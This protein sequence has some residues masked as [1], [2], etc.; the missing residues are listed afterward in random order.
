MKKLICCLLS[1][2]LIASFPYKALAAEATNAT[3][4][5]TKF[6]FEEITV[7]QL[8]TT[9]DSN[10]DD[11]FICSL[12]E[13]ATVIGKISLEQLQ[14]CPTSTFITEEVPEITASVYAVQS[15]DFSGTQ[16]NNIAI[17]SA[18]NPYVVGGNEDSITLNIRS[19][20]WTPEG[21]HLNIGFLLLDGGIL[22]VP[23]THYTGGSASGSYTFTDVESGRYVAAVKNE[24]NTSIITGLMRYTVS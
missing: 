11:H 13:N 5:A 16:K 7:V 2:I 3:N 23:E 22:Y 8:T 17:S 10:S 12:D 14:L 18:N 19:C 24:S 6:D 4:V 15:L 20:L 21:N 1:I 9:P